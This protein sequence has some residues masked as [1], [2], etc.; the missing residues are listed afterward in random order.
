MRSLGIA[1]CIAAL[2]VAA[3]GGESGNAAP[4]QVVP[5]G[6]ASCG[7]STELFTRFPVDPSAIMGWVPLGA[8]SPP[9]HTF[10]TDHQYIYLTTFGTS[11]AATTLVAPGRITVTGAR[12]TT[13]S[14]GS[15]G[16]DYSL[17]FMPCADVYADF[18]HVTS[19]EPAL[20]AQLGAFD[21]QCVAYS[22]NAGL[23][24]E[25]CY[26]RPV[27]IVVEAG[28]PIGT[29]K[30]LDLSLFDRR[31]PAH[32]FANAARWNVSSTGFDR[33]HVVPFSAYYREP[34]R[35]AVRAMLGSFDGRARRTVEPVGG[36]IDWDVAGTAQG[37]WF[38]PG[39]PTAPETPHLAITPD[40]V[41]PGQIAVSIGTSQP[42]VSPGAYRFVP[43]ST[44]SVNR[45]PVEVTP[46]GA[47]QC[48]EVGYG[49]TDIRTIAL[50]QLTD[51]TTLRMETR[52]GP[53]RRCADEQP[54]A[55][56][57]RAFTYVR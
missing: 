19:V 25:A 46:G 45:A 27:S 50:V 32:S 20:L 31:I 3:C 57:S 6:L 13:Y 49:E 21:Q 43:R 39:L 26:T 1:I 42:D 17:N 48:W 33:S 28:T 23:D 56:T 34:E 36:R 7:A 44:G 24:V 16:S 37:T 40:H 38:S 15:V 2:V 54:Y 30:G 12:R 52:P 53:T 29:T 47:I 10:P 14:T 22:P 8:M 11:A 9:G 55:F 51:A 4:T 5:K 35:T 18:G 41:D